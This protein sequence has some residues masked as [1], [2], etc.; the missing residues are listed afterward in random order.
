MWTPKD[1][2][3]VDYSFVALN[4]GLCKTNQEIQSEKNVI[5]EKGNCNGEKLSWSYLY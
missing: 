3:I 5:A 2:N 4:F 1:L